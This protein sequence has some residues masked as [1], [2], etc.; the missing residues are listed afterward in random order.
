MKILRR[1]TAQG[2]KLLTFQVVLAFEMNDPP[3]CKLVGRVNKN[4]HSLTLYL[5]VDETTLRM[6][7]Q[8]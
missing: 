1:A 5:T 7:N 4:I 2:W 6:R 8:G 3:Q